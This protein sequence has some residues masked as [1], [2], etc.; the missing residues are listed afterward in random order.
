M[1][2][3]SILKNPVSP[4]QPQKIDKT[5]H[6]SA[7]DSEAA[8]SYKIDGNTKTLEQVRSSERKRGSL[9]SR[10]SC[11]TS[12]V[13][14]AKQ[15]PVPIVDEAN[16][17]SAQNGRGPLTLQAS[18]Q[19]QRKP[20]DTQELHMHM[21]GSESAHRHLP[22][23]RIDAPRPLQGHMSQ[24]PARPAV[25]PNPQ[26]HGQPSVR[27]TGQELP[28][29]SSPNITGHAQGQL[30]LQPQWLPSQPQRP[31]I[32]VQMTQPTQADDVPSHL[33]PVVRRG[34]PN[35][36]LFNPYKRRKVDKQSSSNDLHVVS[37]NSNYVMHNFKLQ[38]IP[39]ALDNLRK[40]FK[41]SVSNSGGNQA[42]YTTSPSNQ[43]RG[44][45][46]NQSSSNVHPVVYPE[47]HPIHATDKAPVNPQ[48]LSQGQLVERV[49]YPLTGPRQTSTE[50]GPRVM[51]T[52]PRHQ[53]QPARAN[54]QPVQ[55]NGTMYVVREYQV[56]QQGAPIQAE[57]VPPSHIAAPL[58]HI[59]PAPPGISRSQ[60]HPPVQSPGISSTASPSGR[61]PG[62]PNVGHDPRG[63][64]NQSGNVVR[65]D[66]PGVQLRTPPPKPSA[67]IVVVQDGIVLS[68]NMRL[69]ETMAQIDNYELFACQ[70]GAEST[71]P[72]IMWK[73]IG[74]VKAL[75]LPM[76]CTLSQFSSGNKYN[77]AVR[78]V[79]DQER[80]GPFSDPCTIS[81]T[82]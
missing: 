54:G 61:H 1:A 9:D 67:S 13:E 14:T 68:W 50:Y 71:A 43:P 25:S 77:F 47:Q 73:K 52:H 32:Q 35:V 48:G 59:A 74:I 45:Y 46:F 19:G 29:A 79:D 5:H 80:A 62:D 26:T 2:D 28:A 70:D 18:S 34:P 10:V 75:P 21:R 16:R 66:H 33:Y 15:V 42:V 58:Q 23:A 82:S 4:N 60:P 44:P 53:V 51:S 3:T 39:T 6:A 27:P 40:R 65:N 17:S 20:S 56:P 55:P 76:A 11:N 49:F 72:P 38:K 24:P 41:K 12:E 22:E 69:D 78:A 7:V 81:L 36:T 63:T 64:A 30:T 8:D 57:R 31:N 37:S